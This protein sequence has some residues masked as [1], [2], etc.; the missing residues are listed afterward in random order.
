M[1]CSSCRGSHKDPVDEGTT[2]PINTS[3]VD[4]FTFKE[5][6][7]LA[8]VGQAPY[9]PPDP[10][11]NKG[12]EDAPPFLLG[13][14]GSEDEPFLL[15]QDDTAAQNVNADQSTDW[16]IEGVE[17]VDADA[18]RHMT[19]FYTNLKE[20]Y[21]QRDYTSVLLTKRGYDERVAFGMFL[22]EGGDCRSGYLAGTSTAYKWAKKYH[23]VTVGDY[24]KVLVLRPEEQK[25]YPRKK[26]GAVDVSA[27]RL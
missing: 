27:T 20:L 16:V 12:S 21:R 17:E 6:P 8:E 4:G 2:T 25:N 11:G 1:N 23:V 5:M 24:S 14:E 9:A 19:A 26:K 7:H 22:V 3:T 15:L 18:H 13:N 10:E